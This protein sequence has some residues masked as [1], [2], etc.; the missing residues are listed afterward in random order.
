MLSWAIQTAKTKLTDSTY[1]MVEEMKK[2]HTRFVNPTGKLRGAE[3]P[4]SRRRTKVFE[5]PRP[6]HVL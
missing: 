6:D 3:P 5:L 1:R 4:R 2:E